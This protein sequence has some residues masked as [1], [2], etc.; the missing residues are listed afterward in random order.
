MSGGGIA[1]EE[2]E[3]SGFDSLVA[4]Q[5]RLP[6]DY[7]SDSSPHL[8]E[9]VARFVCSVGPLS[10][11]HAYFP[12]PFV[13]AKASLEALDACDWFAGTLPDSLAVALM[14]DRAEETG[15]EKEAAEGFGY[16]EET[17]DGEEEQENFGYGEDEQETAHRDLFLIRFSRRAD[18]YAVLVLDSRRGTPPSRWQISS[19]WSFVRVH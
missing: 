15:G 18:G 7:P 1:Y 3:E 13:Q 14:R 5:L 8:P 19:S 17:L 4:T 16:G 2:S 9:P 10:R 11:L 12:G 6:D